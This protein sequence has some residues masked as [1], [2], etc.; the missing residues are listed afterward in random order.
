[1][2]IEPTINKSPIRWIRK[3]CSQC[4]EVS[5]FCVSDT[6]VCDHC[7]RKNAKERQ[8][9][10]K[11]LPFWLQEDDYCLYQRDDYWVATRSNHKTTRRV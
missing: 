4:N 7:R 10:K 2:E 3:V 8:K 5:S 9:T 6:E 1:M 11:L